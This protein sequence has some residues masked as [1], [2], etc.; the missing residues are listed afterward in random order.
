VVNAVILT[1]ICLS[2]L[3]TCPSLSVN[4]NN[5]KVIPQV[6][7]HTHTHSTIIHIHCLS[8]QSMAHQQMHVNATAPPPPRPLRVCPALVTAAYRQ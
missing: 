3:A 5:S 7:T 8:M 2:V 1:F 6:I 4:V